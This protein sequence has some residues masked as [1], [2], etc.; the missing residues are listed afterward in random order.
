M[1]R[2]SNGMPDAQLLDFGVIKQI[3]IQNTISP[4]YAKIELLPIPCEALENLSDGSNGEACKP[5]SRMC[6][7]L[8]SGLT[9]SQGKYKMINIIHIHFPVFKSWQSTKNTVKH[10]RTMI[11]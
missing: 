4:Q 8:H 7:T 2:T 5:R 1:L 11:L 3:N 10:G 6:D 9:K